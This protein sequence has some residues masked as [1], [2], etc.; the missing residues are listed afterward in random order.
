MTVVAL[1][2]ITYSVG[3]LLTYKLVTRVRID[4]AGEN[5]T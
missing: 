5:F 1:G 3:H 4:G 2:V